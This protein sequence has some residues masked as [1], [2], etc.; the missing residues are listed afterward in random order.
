M[1]TNLRKKEKKKVSF[2]AVNLD[3]IIPLKTLTVKKNNLNFCSLSICDNNNDFCLCVFL[4]VFFFFVFVFLLLFFRFYSNNL[5]FICRNE[6][7]L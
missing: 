7:A 3:L 5:D 6:R 4:C 1:K 2:I